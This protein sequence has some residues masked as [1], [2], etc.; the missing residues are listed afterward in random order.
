MGRLAKTIKWDDVIIRMKAGCSAQ[1]IA[2]T[3][4]IHVDTLYDRFINEFGMSFPDKK[5]EFLEDGEDDI[6]YMQHK[7]AISGS[8]RMLLWLGQVRLGQKAP[9]SSTSTY[10]LEDKVKIE[11]MHA[12]LSAMSEALNSS[13]SNSSSEV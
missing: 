11:Q 4:E 10:S 13:R 8:E 3:F 1:S 12:Q 9:E 7:K 2:N 5:K 6:R